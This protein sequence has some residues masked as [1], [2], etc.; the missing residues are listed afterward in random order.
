MSIYRKF[1]NSVCRLFSLLPAYTSFCSGLEYLLKIRD[2]ILVDSNVTWF[3]ISSVF[4]AGWQNCLLS[5]KISQKYTTFL[6]NVCLIN[7]HI[8]IYQHARCNSMLWNSLWFYTVFFDYFYM[9]IIDQTFNDCVS[10]EYT[11]FYISTC[12]HVNASWFYCV[13]WRLCMVINVLV[14][15]DWHQIWYIG[16][17]VRQ[18]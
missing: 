16:S 10:N 13:F 11:H 5:E 12:S 4:W 14:P 18:K 6:S 2:I 17:L 3:L 15:S 9:H 1:W 8:L 7:T